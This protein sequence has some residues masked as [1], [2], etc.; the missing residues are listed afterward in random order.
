ME[1]GGGDEKKMEEKN[2]RR[3]EEN[4]IKKYGFL[5]V[6]KINIYIYIKNGKTINLV[7]P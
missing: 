6:N 3:K 5:F 7:L 2:D 4:D 1:V